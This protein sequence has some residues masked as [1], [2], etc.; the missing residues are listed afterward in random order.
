MK[1]E[2]KSIGGKSYHYIQNLVTQ[3]ER[4]GAETQRLR[5][6]NQLFV[7]DFAL[8]KE[9]DKATAELLA[10]TN[11]QLECLMKPVHQMLLAAKDHIREIQDYLK[12]KEEPSVEEKQ[13]AIIRDQENRISSL[14]LDNAGLVE[15]TTKLRMLLAK[16]K[17]EEE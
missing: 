5:H 4:L 11:I 1:E 16:A 15:E 7:K 3:M 9:P 10:D 12:G 13:E 17:K 8:K 14:L 6:H 2:E